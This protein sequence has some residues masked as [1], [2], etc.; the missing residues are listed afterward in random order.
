[1]NSIPLTNLIAELHQLLDA[2]LVGMVLLSVL[3]A[4]R[5]DYQMGMNVLSVNVSCDNDLV[6]VEGFLCKLHRYLVCE[7]GLDFIS[8]RKALHQMIVEPSVRL[9]IQVLGCSHFIESSLGRTIDSG[10]ETL[11]LGHGL[12]LSADVVEDVF[13]AA[14]CLSFI[15]DKMDYGHHFTTF[16]MSQT[17][18]VTAMCFSISSSSLTE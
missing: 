5:I 1:M 4:D 8:A 18:A 13:H 9:V 6:I 15:V 17:A 2:L 10:H 16:A 3:E 11:V 12:F 7:F 14:S